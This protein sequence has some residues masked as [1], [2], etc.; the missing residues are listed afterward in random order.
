MR[1]AEAAAESV[2]ARLILLGKVVGIKFSLRR[3]AAVIAFRPASV[4]VADLSLVRSPLRLLALLRSLPLV[5]DERR[6][7]CSRRF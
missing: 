5:T 3:L 4:R 7:R 6:A 2:R 1:F